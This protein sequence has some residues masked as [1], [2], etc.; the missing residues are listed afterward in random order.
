MAVDKKALVAREF[1]VATFGKLKDLVRQLEDNER[2]IGQEVGPAQ[3]QVRISADDV[4]W[5]VAYKTSAEG[6]EFRREIINPSKG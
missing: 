2:R 5:F 1:S 3:V 4:A 6:V